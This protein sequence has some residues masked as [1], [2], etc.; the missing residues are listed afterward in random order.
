M[1]PVLF[2]NSFLE[3]LLKLLSSLVATCDLL[4]EPLDSFGDLLLTHG[5]V[6]IGLIEH[7][8]YEVANTTSKN[9]TNESTPLDIAF[10]ILEQLAE[11]PTLLSACYLASFFPVTF[12]NII[13]KF[14]KETFSVLSSHATFLHD[15][16]E[17]STRLVDLFLG[18]L[19]ILVT[20]HQV[21][22]AVNKLT[23]PRVL[24]QCSDSTIS[25]LAT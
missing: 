20:K 7:A 4:V 21:D 2:S 5:F 1:F 19:S 23:C 17:L 11:Q 24:P 8:S 3:F 14:V 15:G 13:I 12:S 10:A 16:L 9:G 25:F 18:H 22:G 6:D